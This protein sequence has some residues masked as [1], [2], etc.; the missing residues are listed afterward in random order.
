MPVTRTLPEA[1]IPP[2]PEGAFLLLRGN[3][4]GQYN[5]L[6]QEGSRDTLPGS[7]PQ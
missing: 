3:F 5:V 7:D 4:E 6:H 1:Q 2:V